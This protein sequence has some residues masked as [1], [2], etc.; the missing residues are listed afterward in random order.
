[1]MINRSYNHA[2]FCVAI[3]DLLLRIFE[4]QFQFKYNDLNSIIFLMDA[5][6]LLSEPN[7]SVICSFFNK[8]SGAL[9]LKQLSFSKLESILKIQDEAKGLKFS[10]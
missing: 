6:C 7:F 1:M 8:F 10:F 4:R 2:F 9:G 5:N 3:I